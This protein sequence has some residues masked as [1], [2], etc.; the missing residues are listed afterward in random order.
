[1]DP[2]D[3]GGFDRSNLFGEWNY[4]KANPSKGT[5]IF[6][7]VHPLLSSSSFSSFSLSFS[8]SSSSF[9]LLGAVY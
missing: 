4:F 5:M 7:E 3:M 8:F 9:R 1:M 6:W 2:L